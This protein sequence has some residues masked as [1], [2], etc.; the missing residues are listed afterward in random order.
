MALSC[1]CEFKGGM[2]ITPKMLEAHYKHTFEALFFWEMIRQPGRDP[3]AII[4]LSQARIDFIN[5]IDE[6]YP[7]LEV[8]P[9]GSE[10]G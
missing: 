6:L 9:P 10:G 1:G 8:Y 5:A 3:F 4:R 7:G 2:P